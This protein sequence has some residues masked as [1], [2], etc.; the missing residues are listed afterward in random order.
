MI[1]P[2]WWFP[3]KTLVRG[4]G[5][6]CVARVGERWCGA[7]GSRL[8]PSTADV[9]KDPS[10]K[11]ALDAVKANEPQT[12]EDQIRFCQIPAPSFKEEVRGK[13]L[14]RVF[15]QIGLQNMRV[16][17]V[18]NVLGE[19]RGRGAAP[20]PRARRASRH[21]LSGRDRRPREARGQ[22]P[23]RAGHRRRLPRPRG[24]RRRS[25]AR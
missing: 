23:A 14:E 20:A 17:K 11:A 7:G 4:L 15:Q 13:E 24:A 10:V 21:G 9:L 5:G 2:K 22:H 8:R 25:P 19:L 18:G 3:G 12:I 6:L 1:R 16:D